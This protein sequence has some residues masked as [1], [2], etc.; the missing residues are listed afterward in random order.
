[1]RVVQH[2]HRWAGGG[3]H[4]PDRGIRGRCRRARRGRHGPTPAQSPRR[5]VVTVASISLSASV[6][7]VAP[8][9]AAS[10]WRP[11]A[12]WTSKCCGTTWRG[13]TYRRLS[14][15]AR[16]AR[17]RPAHARAHAPRAQA[18]PTCRSRPRRIA[19]SPPAPGQPGRA[20]AGC[21]RRAVNL[22]TSALLAAALWP[23]I[24]VR[25]SGHPRRAHR[26]HIHR[27]RPMYAARAP[28]ILNS[29][30]APRRCGR[31]WRG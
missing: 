29:I 5:I 22:P 3:A 21:R 10:T 13:A 30:I 25:H 24:T 17:R 8:R 1:M 14:T 27:I 6:T 16:S 23:A 31:S 11:I 12:G 4:H 20:L 2:Q 28:P 26:P 15:H 7:G 19:S 18:C 9:M